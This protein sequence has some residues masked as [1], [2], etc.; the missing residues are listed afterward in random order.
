MDNYQRHKA[1]QKVELEQLE[2]VLRYTYDRVATGIELLGNDRS[3]EISREGD[4]VTYR[5][6]SD[7]TT[8]SLYSADGMLIEQGKAQSG[9]PLTLSVKNRPSGVYIVKAGKE[10]IK[11]LRK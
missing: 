8:V 5:N 10:T 4:A 9:Q 6:L 3:V 11:L 7:G 1:L 2:N